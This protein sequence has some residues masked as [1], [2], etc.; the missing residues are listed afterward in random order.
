MYYP[1]RKLS[2]WYFSKRAL[3]YWAVLLMDCLI[4]YSMGLFAHQQFFGALK[5]LED[6]GPLS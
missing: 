6:F 2:N 3:P 1:L 5:V 4:V